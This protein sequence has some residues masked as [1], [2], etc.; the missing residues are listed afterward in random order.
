ML[1]N[2]LADGSDYLKVGGYVMG[3]NAVDLNCIKWF[4]EQKRDRINRQLQQSDEYGLNQSLKDSVHE[5]SA[6]DNHPADLGSETYEREKD[7][8]LREL[9][10]R[11]LEKIDDALE[12]I[13][14]GKYGICE[15][16]GRQIAPDRLTALPETT[17]CL[18][19]ELEIEDEQDRTSRPVEETL[20][21]PPFSRTFL[22]DSDYSGTDGEDIWQDVAKYGTSETATDLGGDFSF[23]NPQ[24]D[25]DEEIGTVEAVEKLPYEHPDEEADEVADEEADEDPDS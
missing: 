12:R 2:N 20:L 5:L 25:G 10:R 18:D 6:Y 23:D 21:Y 9:S 14:E 13:A 24:I 4:L 11:T 17:L 7:L 3:T 15:H 19:C 1:R 16:C 8:S 22:D